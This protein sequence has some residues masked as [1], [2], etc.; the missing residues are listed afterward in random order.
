MLGV[1]ADVSL[2]AARIA[3][4]HQLALSEGQRL[5][6]LRIGGGVDPGMGQHHI[7]R[8]RR[9]AA[10]CR[11]RGK[12]P[13]HQR[14]APTSAASSHFALSMLPVSNRLFVPDDTLY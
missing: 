8:D 7:G 5:G 4:V 11:R 10:R 9:R 1:R 3:D 13:R 6:Q 12:R 14:P 2:H